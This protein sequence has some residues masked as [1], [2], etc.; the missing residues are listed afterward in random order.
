MFYRTIIGKLFPDFRTKNIIHSNFKN[1]PINVTAYFPLNYVW[2]WQHNI[3]VIEFPD[4]TDFGIKPVSLAKDYI[5]I[6]L[7]NSTFILAGFGFGLSDIKN[8][9]QHT[10]EPPPIMLHDFALPITQLFINKRVENDN[11][12]QAEGAPMLYEKNGKFYQIGV[13]YHSGT[14]NG[15]RTSV[16]GDCEFIEE[17]TK[18]EVE[19]ESVAPIYIYPTSTAL[20]S[21][22]SNTVFQ[23]VNSK[24]SSMASKISFD[25]KLLIITLTMFCI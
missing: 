8:N 3:A 20:P 17:V 19:C 4:G 10:E 24:P 22:Q 12:S 6:Y 21:K 16:E 1:E 11:L 7:D 2:P 18:N 15:S 23:N 9:V 5:S 13:N 25:M 14:P